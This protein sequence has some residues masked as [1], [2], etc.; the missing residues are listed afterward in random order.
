MNE[1]LIH[2]LLDKAVFVYAKTMPNIPHEYTLRRTWKNDND[3]V[4]VV[5]YIRLHGVKERYYKKHYIYYYY[6]G[7]KYWTMGCPLHNCD[8]T[9]TILINRAKI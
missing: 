8:K 3:F 6:N 4:K 1:K 7:Y 9:G 2:K 5:I